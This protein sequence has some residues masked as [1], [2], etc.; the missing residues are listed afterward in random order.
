LAGL[1]GQKPA[2]TAAAPAPKSAL[3]VTAANLTGTW[4]ASRA[5]GSSFVFML[6]SSAYSWKF[7][8]GAKT[9]EYTGEF[10]VADGLLILKRDGTPVMI[11]Q[12]TISDANHFN[13]KLSSENPADPGLSFTR[14]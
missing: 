2:T 7:T 13:F 1:S 10:T 9:Q 3:P 12:V 6:T 5:D 4:T 14:K 8:K 11:G